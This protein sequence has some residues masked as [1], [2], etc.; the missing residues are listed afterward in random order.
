[1]RDLNKHQRWINLC[2][3]LSRKSKFERHKHASVL[4][5]GG[6]VISIG[7][8]KE[9][10]GKLA[11]KIYGEKKW[12]A[13][14]DCLTSLSQRNI[15]NAILYVAGITHRDHLINSKPCECCQEYLKRFKLKSIYYSDNYGNIVKYS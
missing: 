10:S 7:I 8:N 14:V 6:K 15:D 9:K 4:V 5:Q 3:K 11:D 1:L 2:L 13:E 12:H